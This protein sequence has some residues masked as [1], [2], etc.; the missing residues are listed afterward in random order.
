MLI[1]I[2]LYFISLHIFTFV[3]LFLLIFPHFYLLI[4]SFLF[5]V[6]FL[7]FV[8][9]YYHFTYL[10]FKDFFFFM[11]LLW[12]H[13][14]AA[15]L[16]HW[17]KW[18]YFGRGLRRCSSTAQRRWSCWRCVSGSHVSADCSHTSS[19]PAGPW[20]PLLWSKASRPRQHLTQQQTHRHVVSSSNVSNRC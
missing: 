15:L 19:H 5:L 2:L 17:E 9:L 6:I 18:P 7:H 14:G 1:I 3:F 13:N 11:E 8:H 12:L 4:Y 20:I 10:F 16:K